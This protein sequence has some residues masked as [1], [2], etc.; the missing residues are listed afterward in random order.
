MNNAHPNARGGRLQRPPTL[1]G[2]HIG[3]FRQ[4]L[5]RHGLT[6]GALAL[7]VSA[8]PNAQEYIVRTTDSFVS[9]PTGYLIAGIMLLAFFVYYQQRRGYRRSPRNNL[10]LVYLLYISV[11]EELTFRLLLPLAASS[12]VDF[13]LAVIISNLIF[14]TIHYVTLR[15]HLRNCLFVFIGGMGFSHM[16]ASHQDLTAVILAH[17]FFTFLN[18]PAPPAGD[19]QTQR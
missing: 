5:Y 16:L 14:A 1:G 10:W 6:M 3:T 8:S 9:H 15:W 11:V 17:W 7:L 12:T 4:I 13:Y 19:R 2:S 18:T